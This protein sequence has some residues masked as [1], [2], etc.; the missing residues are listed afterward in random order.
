MLLGLCGM[1]GG[2]VCSYMNKTYYGVCVLIYDTQLVCES[3]I[4][5]LI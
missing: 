2:Q 4:M 1:F 3:L 5:S